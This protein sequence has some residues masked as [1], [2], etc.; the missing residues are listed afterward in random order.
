[1]KNTCLC[2]IGY[3]SVSGYLTKGNSGYTYGLNEFGKYELEIINSSKSL[4]EI[5]D[6]LFN[7]AHY[8][9]D[10]DV[11]FQDKQTCGLSEEE[12]I[13]ISFSKGVFVEGKTF[14]LDY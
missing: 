10:F 3:I 13:P 6:F 14:K 7:M 2:I 4:E 11:V 5:G 1:M 9:L 12:K 8:V